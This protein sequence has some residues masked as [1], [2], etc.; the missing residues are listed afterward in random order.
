MKAREQ[1]IKILSTLETLGYTTEVTTGKLAAA[2]TI[3]RDTCDERTIKNWT[4]TLIAFG[5]LEE[6][7]SNVYKIN[8][9]P[10]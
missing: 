3:T 7:T 2:I 1:S 6:K 9:P 8:K 4:R 5:F 10:I